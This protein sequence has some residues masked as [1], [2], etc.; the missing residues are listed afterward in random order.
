LDHVE[1]QMRG[2]AVEQRYE[3]AASLRRRRRRL[4][5]VLTR[6]GGL[7]EA[8]HARPKL[9]LGTHPTRSE[10]DALWIA[11]GR[12]VDWGPVTSADWSDL[13]A[14]ADEVLR[15]GGRIGELGAHVPPGE[16]DEVRI[17]GTWL[18]SHP[19]T[20]QLALHPRPS[21]QELATF[22]EV[23]AAGSRPAPSVLGE[24]ELHHDR[25]DL[26]GADADR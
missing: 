5:L 25:L 4:G 15:R 6:L 19:D 20:P 9:V 11:G 24:G 18:A 10:F 3:R 21:R 26:V 16:I 12:L 13:D 2:A 8:T 14:R 22:L 7:L 23:A 1:A 17:L